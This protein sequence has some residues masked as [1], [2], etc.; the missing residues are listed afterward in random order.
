M[1]ESAQVPTAEVWWGSGSTPAWRV[2]LGFAAKGLPYT[3]HLISFSNRDTKTPA[4]LALNAR[5]K[6]PVVR[7]GDLVLNE[8]LAILA[9]LDRRAPEGPALFGEDAA[10]CGR[11]WRACMEY[12]SHG[13]P[14]FS[15][16]ARPLLFGAAPDVGALEPA[17]P[18]V[19]AELDRLE[20][21]IGDGAH[22]EGHNVSAADIV[23]YCGLRFLDRA[24]SRPAAQAHELGLG[25]LLSRRPG[26]VAWARSV[27]SLP[28]FAATVPPHWLEGTHPSAVTLG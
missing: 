26:L 27:E 17:V 11:I 14:S 13:G 25:P 23:W 3:S 10:A 4:F 24:L 21:W 1:G 18:A 16:V 19:N 9:W 6:V 8:S 2:L 20:S 28:G 12:E 7:E 15:A 5:G 22:I